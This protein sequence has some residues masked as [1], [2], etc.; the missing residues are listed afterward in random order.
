VLRPVRR[1]RRA[2]HD[3]LRH[4]RSGRRRDR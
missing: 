3:V 4:P 1:E 2:C